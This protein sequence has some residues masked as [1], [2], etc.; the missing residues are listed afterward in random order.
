MDFFL[1]NIEHSWNKLGI[2]YKRIPACLLFLYT[3]DYQ[4]QLIIELLRP[5]SINRP[6]RL[7]TLT[8]Y[9]SQFLPMITSPKVYD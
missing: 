1:V 6:G 3:L 8:S 5:M 4:A 2:L 9:F 7:K